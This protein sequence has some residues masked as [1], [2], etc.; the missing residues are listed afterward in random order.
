MLA[1][2]AVRSSKALTGAAGPPSG[3]AAHVAVGRRP[4]FLTTQA[5]PRMPDPRGGQEEAAASL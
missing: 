5:S 4:P 3:T 2:A 1:G